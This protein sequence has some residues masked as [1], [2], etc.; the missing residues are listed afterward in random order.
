[1][2]KNNKGH[3]VAIASVGSLF[4]LPYSVPYSTSK[5]ATRGLMTALYNECR[6][7]NSNIKFT[8]VL[9]YFV[10]TKIVDTD[11][12]ILSNF[13]PM[14]DTKFVAEKIL[15]AQR[16]NLVEVSIPKI[17]KHFYTIG[18]LLPKAVQDY[19]FD[20]MRPDLKT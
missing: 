11:R 10:N 7:T 4:G 18:N 9:P 17:W 13:L 19:L 14:L 8:T 5:Y 12:L 1:M 6:Q 20:L 2:M 3:I 16:A 15:E